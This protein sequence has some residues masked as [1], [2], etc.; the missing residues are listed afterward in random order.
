MIFVLFIFLLCSAALFARGKKEEEKE[1]QNTEFILC[2]TAFDVSALP[3]SQQVLG[4]VLQKELVLDLSR[5]H[6]RIRDGSEIIRYEELAMTQ[7]MHEAA[8]ALAA[9]R[10]ERDALLYQGLARWKYRKEIKRINKEIKEL[11]AAYKKAEEEIPLITEKPLFIISESNTG[12]TFPPPPGKGREESFLKANSADALLEGKF[13]LVYG[14][15]YAEFRFF[16]RGASFVHEDSTIFSQEDLNTAADEL[17]SRFLTALVNSEL[18]RISLSADPDY[19]RLELNGRPVKSG[20]TVE[21]PPGP[22]IARASADD[23]QSRERELELEGG[24]TEEIAFVLRPFTMETLGVTLPEQGGSVYMGAMYLGGNREE[25]ANDEEQ[26]TNNEEE[27]ADNKETINDEEIVTEITDEYIE[28]AGD[29]ETAGE[30]ETAEER[31]PGFFSVYVPVGQYRYI[32]VETEDGLTGEAIVKGTAGDEIRV[33]TLQPRK[34]PGKDDKPVEAK[35]RKFY[36]AFGR[37]MV[38]LPIAFFINGYY[39][40]YFNSYAV[41]ASTSGKQD[42]LSG[43]RNMYYVSMGAWIATGFFLAESLVR[44]GVYVHTATKES[45]PLWE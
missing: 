38:T 20:E 1:P 11:E 31:K 13:R 40:A 35:R 16:T 45:I 29:T 34:L 15:V 18:A 7:A 33:V 14:R 44:M 21:L 12:G 43:A 25:T 6:H 26:I 32:R 3:P 39:Q 30:A 19:A 41:G 8:A 28:T 27:A 10:S 9:K 23:H 24:D 5:I 22:V 4:S 36:G 42:M 37:F 17:K 2:I